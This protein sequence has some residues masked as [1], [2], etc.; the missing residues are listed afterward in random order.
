M[1]LKFCVSLR[2]SG[3]H[4]KAL[5]MRTASWCSLVRLSGSC[6]KWPSWP[7]SA[8]SARACR[9]SHR[10][11]PGS[12]V[13]LLVLCRNR[14]FSTEFTLF[15]SPQQLHAVIAA[16][17]SIKSSQK[18]KK[19]LE[20]IEWFASGLDVM[21]NERVGFLSHCCLLLL[22]RLFWHLETTWTAAREELC[23]DSSCKV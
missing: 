16:S 8:T 13:K 18:L 14:Q 22:Y 2:R 23:M 17:V 3:N 15:V 6:R 10:W 7:S 9:C 11:E 1:R 21:L 20:V 5:Q 4:W 12:P 19:I